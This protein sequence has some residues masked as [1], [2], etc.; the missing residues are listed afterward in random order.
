VGV[1]VDGRKQAACASE[2]LV[3]ALLIKMEVFDIDVVVEARVAN[4]QLVGRHSHNGTC[5]VIS[6]IGLSSRVPLTIA[7][8]E[9]RDLPRILSPQHNLVVGLVPARHCCESGAGE[10]GEGMEVQPI[11]N[12]PEQIGNASCR[13][14]KRQGRPSGGGCARVQRH[15]VVADL[16]LIQDEE[17]SCR[18]AAN[19]S[20]TGMPTRSMPHMA[21]ARPHVSVV[22]GLTAVYKDALAPQF[23]WTSV[24]S[25]YN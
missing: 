11:Q 19:R 16:E 3:P 18:A 25:L 22:L 6:K 9:L 10:L 24:S 2:S 21:D 8:V 4:V 7:V 14:Q 23:V 1:G 15:T 13:T 12:K 20:V 17:T 5:Q